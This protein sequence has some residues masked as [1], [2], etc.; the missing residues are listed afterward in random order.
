MEWDA[1]G[2]L[3]RVEDA[4]AGVTTF[5]YDAS[6]DRLIRRDASVSTLYLP[7]MEIHFERSSLVT[8]ALRFYEHNGDPIAV[9][10]IDNNVSWTFSDHHGTGQLAVESVGGQVTQRRFT[11]FGADRG[12]GGEWPSERGFV[13]GVIDDSTGLTQIGARAYDAALGRF[14]SPD[15]IVDLTDPQQMHGYTYANSNPVSFTDPDG[16]FL[17]KTWNKV[18]RAA[19]RVKNRVRTSVRTR[20][21]NSRA[22]VIRQTIR[23]TTI[24][25]QRRTFNRVERATRRV[26]FRRQAWNTM[27]GLTAS[28]QRINSSMWVADGISRTIG[29]PTHKETFERFGGD[30]N[31]RSFRSVE[32]AFDVGIEVATGPIPAGSAMRAL[33]NGDKLKDVFSR[34]R[35]GGNCNSFAAGT[36]VVMADGTTKPIEEVQVGD[37]VLATDPETGVEGTREVLATIVGS[38]T[39]T[40][41][42]ITVDTAVQ[43]EVTDAGHGVI[44]E[45]LG[46][47]GPMVLGD[48]IIATDG[49]PFWS[50]ELDAWIDAI[51]LVPG[52][53]LVSS[54]GT[55]VQVTGIEA[56]TQPATV[57]NLTIQGIHTYYVVSGDSSVLVHNATPGQKCDLTL[58]AGPNAREGVALEKG[59]IE[60]DGVRDLINESGNA[61]G[62]H[63]CTARIPGTRKGDWIPDHQPPSSL[64]TPGSPQTA[65]PHCQA[66]ARRQGGVVSQLSQGKSKKEW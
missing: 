39:K 52:M 45:A 40:L 11:A 6:G 27:Y 5:T 53:W 2:L 13:G 14:I 48:V 66:C 16:L 59:N 23:R 8:Q 33:R 49:H 50:P 21:N 64:V 34:F 44:D 26:P 1:E 9:R 20:W 63:T 30:K 24:G 36:P 3:V 41:V 28:A 55:L 22:R 56:W 62:C 37:Q 12:T 60:A 35:R 29:L 42:E 57:H 32:L 25:I 65:Y 46:R 58:G 43:L 4:A 7:G 31:S 51:D 10:D 61:Y 18:R 15:P 47:P 19:S 17:R 54:E 38:G